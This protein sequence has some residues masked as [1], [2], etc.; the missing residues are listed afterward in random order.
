MPSRTPTQSATLLIDQLGPLLGQDLAA[1]NKDFD[2]AGLRLD[3]ASKDTLLDAYIEFIF[4][5]GFAINDQKE[6]L[7]VVQGTANPSERKAKGSIAEVVEVGKVIPDKDVAV[8]KIE[9]KDL[10]TLPV[11]TD[12][13]LNSGSKIYVAGYPADATFN[14]GSTAEG[15]LEATV[16]AGSVS[17]RR[18]VEAGYSQVQHTAVTQGGSSG[19]PIVNE[20]GE[21]V[22]I[23]AGT[24]GDKGNIQVG[25]PATVVRDFLSRKNV[26]PTPGAVTTQYVKALDQMDEKH[27]KDALKTLERAERCVPGPPVHH[28]QDLVRS[29]ADL[30]R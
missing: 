17:A 1:V 9:G 16:S 15:N 3:E 24:T 23:H 11:G 14:L 22:A 12:D 20:Y 13:G 26:T 7:A 8:L 4:E 6:T 27:Y 21:L 18:Q 29:A 19:G 5:Q 25:I 28:R 10:Y 30:G 2:D